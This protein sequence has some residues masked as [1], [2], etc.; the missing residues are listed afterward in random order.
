MRAVVVVVAV[1]VAGILGLGNLAL[2]EIYQWE[3][4]DPA[5][6]SQGVRQST[7]VCPDGA[8][9]DA[10]PNA[11][12]DFRDLTQAYLIQ[13]N[14][15]NAQFTYATLT[16]ADLSLANLTNANFSAATLTSTNLTDAV[17]QGAHFEVRNGVYPVGTGLPLA[18]LYSTASYKSGDLT[19]IGLYANN[20]TGGDFAGKNLCNAGFGDAWLTN[21]NLSQ[22][23]LTN[24]NL[25]FARLANADL[26]DAVISG[27]NLMHS[28]FAAVQLYSTASYRSGDLTGIGLRSNSLEGWNFAGKNLSNADLNSAGLAD[29]NLTGANLTNADLSFTWMTNAD[30]TDAVVKGADFYAS[31]DFT[32]T[33]LYSTASYKSGDLAGIGLRSMDLTGGDFAGKNLSHADFSSSLLINADLR[34]ANLSSADLSYATLKN[35][36]LTDAVVKGASFDREWHYLPAEYDGS[37]LTLAQL[38]ST[39]SYKDGDLTGIGLS[40]HNLGG[41][42]FAGKN[43][44]NAN[45]S[46]ANLG[47]ATLTDTDLT[48]AVISGA[49]LYHTGIAVAQ[50]YSTATYRS[51]DLTGIGLGGN[52]LTGCNFAGKNLSNA[53]LRYANLGSATLTNA[54]LSGADTRGA[55]DLGDVASA[56]TTNMIRPDGTIRGLDLAGGLTLVVRNDHGDPNASP[57]APSIAIRIENSMNMGTNG[58]LK[59]L[60]E[61]DTWGSTI[62]FEP[63]IPVSLGGTLVLDFVPGSYPQ[64]GQKFRLF[65]WTGVSPTGEFW[66][67]MMPV[68]AQW[69]LGNL[70]TT[71]YVTLLTPE[72]TVLLLL[73][74]GGLALTRRRA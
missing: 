17:V 49:D 25:S 51:G 52:D 22:A 6:P 34:Q 58:L 47:F 31:R 35:A 67:P 32:S 64:A 11:S 44:S 8:G 39:A 48:D 68:Y 41:G 37:G 23:N 46:N 71:G 73:A 1:A 43:L 63:G 69:D 27:A 38:C 15:T 56:V 12:L 13:A 66:V 24:A 53:V 65:D 59:L 29:A 3:W 2:G 7:S 28:D 60:L 10:I 18:Q 61:T 20:L 36:D 40:W 26:T 42:D 14:L 21:A 57:P 55:L 4:V 19:G 50:L 5:D 74:L 30:L 62:S 72:P 33:Q 9:V 45:L 16:N 70:Y 54:D